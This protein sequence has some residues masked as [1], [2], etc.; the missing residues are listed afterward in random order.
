MIRSYEQLPDVAGA[1]AIQQVYAR[2]G[3]IG[4]SVPKRE[5][6]TAMA[7][8]LSMK[9]VRMREK[10]FFWLTAVAGLLPV[11]GSAYMVALPEGLDK[12][13]ARADLICKARVIGVTAVTNTGFRKVD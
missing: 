4:C 9:T 11:C 12:M 10:L 6:E 13:T 2:N 8:Q 1:G 7:V 3:R 5:H